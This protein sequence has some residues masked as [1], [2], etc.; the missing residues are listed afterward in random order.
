MRERGSAAP[1]TCSSV[2]YLADGEKVDCVPGWDV[3]SGGG[4]FMEILLTSLKFCLA[5]I[6]CRPCAKF[7]IITIYF[8]KRVTGFAANMAAARYI[9]SSSPSFCVCPDACFQVCYCM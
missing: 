8:S 4:P 9:S 5:S 6:K 7:S 3:T 1:C 2:H